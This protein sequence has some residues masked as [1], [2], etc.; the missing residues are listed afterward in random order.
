MNLACGV[1][2]SRGWRSAGLDPTTQV[3]NPV[4]IYCIIILTYIQINTVHT[5]AGTH[6]RVAGVV[7]EHRH[8]HEL[9]LSCVNGLVVTRDME[10]FSGANSAVMGSGVVV[11][12]SKHIRNPHPHKQTNQHT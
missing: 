3:H 4:H 5:R 1:L 10:W 8:V 7:E 9:L 2:R 12:R 6:P 11:D